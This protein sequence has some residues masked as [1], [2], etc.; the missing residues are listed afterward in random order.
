MT[1]SKFGQRQNWLSMSQAQSSVFPTKKIVLLCLSVGKAI[2]SLQESQIPLACMQKKCVNFKRC[3]H[4]C[5][6]TLAA[7]ET[8]GHL[9]EYL[10]AIQLEKSRETLQ[11]VIER[12]QNQNSGEKSKK[13][14]KVITTRSLVQSFSR[15][16]YTQQSITTLLK[17]GSWKQISRAVLPVG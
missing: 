12:S 14:G 10:A 7:A 17:Y 1:C 2:L 6:H 8:P 3:L 16:H 4:L 5:E 13:R 9:E 15:S 11:S